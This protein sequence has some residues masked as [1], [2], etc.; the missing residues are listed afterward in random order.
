[1]PSSEDPTGDES[2]DP[3][4]WPTC[5]AV[6]L[7]RWLDEENSS[8]Q[9]LWRICDACE[10]LV[11]YAFGVGVADLRRRH[12]GEG[13]PE[14][15]R[16]EVAIPVRFPS[17][18]TWISLVEKVIDA[19]DGLESGSARSVGWDEARRAFEQLRDDLLGTGNDAPGEA[20]VALRND[21]AH[22][23][24]I[25]N[26]AGRKLLEESG[27]E[28]RARETFASIQERMTSSQLFYV[29]EDGTYYRLR[30]PEVE[31]I[32]LSQNQIPGGANASRD[33]RDTVVLRDP[34]DPE[35]ALDLAPILGVDAD[36]EA[37]RISEIY[38][39]KRS[40]SLHYNRL[41]GQDFFAEKS[42]DV[43]DRFRELFH[44]EDSEEATAFQRELER[45]ARQLVGRNDELE[46]FIHQVKS[47]H[48]NGGSRIF[49]LEGRAGI[50]KS[51]LMA[52]AAT[53]DKMTGNP[54]DILSIPWHFRT[55]D[56]R[57]SRVVF[58]RHAVNKLI[59]RAPMLRSH[60]GELP[61]SVRECLRDA[62][63]KLRGRFGL[64]SEPAH[65]LD[66]S[67]LDESQLEFCFD[68]FLHAYAAL[69]SPEQYPEA[70]APSV[71]FFLDGLDELPDPE[72]AALALPTDYA[73]TN[74]IWVC[75]GRPEVAKHFETH[76]SVTELSLDPESDERGVPPLSDAGIR[77]IFEERLEEG[78]YKLHELDEEPEAGEENG[79]VRNPFLEAVT[80][81]ADGLPVYAELVVDDILTGHLDPSQLP[82]ELPDS[83]AS[84]HANILNRYGIADMTRLRT[85]VLAT[86]AVA[87]APLTT[88]QL[89]VLLDYWRQ[90]SGD[91]DGRERL[92]VVLRESEAVLRPAPTS[93]G[94][95]GYTLY[96]ETFREHLKES[97]D[98][99]QSLRMARRVLGDATADWRGESLEALRPF[100]LEHG[101]TQLL[102]LN[103][104]GE[105]KQLLKDVS[106]AE[107]VCEAAGPNR[108]AK[109]YSDTAD[110]LPEDDAWRRPLRLMAR[111]IRLER[112]F[113]QAHPVHFFQQRFNRCWWH[114]AP[115]AA[116]FYLERDGGPETAPWD[117]EGP[118]LHTLM[119]EWREA[120][121]EQHDQAW[122][123]AH[124]PIGQPLN[125]AL[126]ET[127]HVGQWLH[128][129]ALSPDGT[130]IAA[131]LEGS[132]RVWNAAD[133]ELVTTIRAPERLNHWV[134]F[135]SDGRSLVT[136]SRGEGL[137]VWDVEAGKS[138]DQQL[139]GE[140]FASSLAAATDA[141]VAGV[142]EY[143]GNF[144]LHSLD[145]F[146]DAEILDLQ[147]DS[148]VHA[149]LSP[150]ASMVAGGGRDGAVVVMSTSDQREITRLD[151]GSDVAGITFG[152][153]GQLLA[154]GNHDGELR[155]YD[156]EAEEELHCFG[157]SEETVKAIAVS[158]EGQSVAYGGDD[159]E[160][161][162]RDIDSG[163]EIARLHGHYN[164]V[165]TLHFTPDGCELI[166][167][168]GAFEIRRW[169][170]SEASKLVPRD[171]YD[172]MRL[173]RIAFDSS[174]ER[175]AY[176]CT[177]NTARIEDVFG[178]RVLATLEG[179]TDTITSLVF[180]PSGE[181]LATGS[182][183]GTARVWDTQT[184]EELASFDKYDSPVH[185][186]AFAPDGDLLAVASEDQRVRGYNLKNGLQ[187]AEN[188]L[189]VM[190][191]RSMD[192]TSDGRFLLTGSTGQLRLSDFRQDRPLLEFHGGLPHAI[193]VQILEGART[194]LGAIW[195]N[196][197]IRVWDIEEVLADYLERE[198]EARL[199]FGHRS[200]ES[201][202][203][204][205]DRRLP[206]KPALV[207]RLPAGDPDEVSDHQVFQG[208]FYD[209]GNRAVTTSMTGGPATRIW[210]IDE[211]SDSSA[212][213]ATL[214]GA[215]DPEGI[216][217]ALESSEPI[218]MVR[219][220]ETVLVRGPAGAA[221]VTGRL[222]G[223]LDDFVRVANAERGIMFAGDCRDSVIVFSVEN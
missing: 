54:N 177:D 169:D 89:Q 13:L 76:E 5:L 17:F 96:H 174:G 201:D 12:P 145:S 68:L 40:N 79:E 107:S 147:D 117:V 150:D 159:K 1:M 154:V 78:R 181:R 80:E 127:R 46:E 142:L 59:D 11:R 198:R 61:E 63:D 160:I 120:W 83:V 119:E 221:E 28:K 197:T 93:S 81:Q 121:E 77:Q 187:V 49:W 222:P 178:H 215:S 186:V 58:L 64:E 21:L 90:L 118:K 87:E 102:E 161:F 45:E 114:D 115:D 6:P 136:D 69:E 146:R 73:R 162:V 133:G 10:L 131:L 50:G 103:R 98:V 100:L 27:H 122:I 106:F 2:L 175:L 84:Y 104:P 41:S 220:D 91:A 99:E 112:H 85:L 207:T 219:L 137:L 176:A 212:P 113:L 179:H 184:G 92:E 8:V 152:P 86:L 199:T 191:L 24:G 216:A 70:C 173:K 134:Q 72:S 183:D 43:L 53:H 188:R 128:D 108:L 124:Q 204:T 148:I 36:E 192:F 189:Y 209:N 129:V 94:S 18:G 143:G 42:G 111:A 105:A 97:D 20:V 149:A 196:G 16:E 56:H 218:P 4:Q 153:D 144:R 60:L 34:R 205:V 88:E 25:T 14:A 130:R 190:N 135:T 195:K 37:D 213:L 19:H 125:S 62:P 109:W 211:S 57:N 38:V 168:T 101:I 116:N 7:Q 164:G 158:P 31:A 39:R 51:T 182:K 217:A 95:T 47:S 193:H 151:A 75:A 23:G 35:A 208:A 206:P 30:G 210:K 202:G 214:D 55:G 155:L 163:L 123:R 180:G 223:Y 194:R 9:R 172:G 157:H 170:L 165:N 29:D 141:P 15:F 140:I 82:T 3:T 66:T 203:V 138:L 33:L 67:D 52:A 139:G 171:D 110:A 166:S 32:P 200:H 44:I 71:V 74:V 185:L 132:I 167:S 22:S 156:V 65:R 48:K 126:V 26:E